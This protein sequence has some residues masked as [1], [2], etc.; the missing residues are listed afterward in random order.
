MT[1]SAIY[2]W[3]PFSGSLPV[4]IRQASAPIDAVVSESGDRLAVAGG[5]TTVSVWDTASGRLIGTFAPP[6]LSRHIPAVPL[7]VVLTADGDVVASGNSD[8][9]VSLWNVPTGKPVK[10]DTLSGGPIVELGATPDGSQLIAVNYPEV[11]AGITPPPTGEVLDASTGQVLATYHSPEGVAPDMNPGAALS[12]DGGFLLAGA[13]GLAPTSPG[14]TEAAYQISSGQA[15]TTLPAAGLSTVSAY[16][17][18]PTQPWSPD[19]TEVI[20]G[21]AI[22]SCDACGL[23]S[24]L[25]ATA[26]SRL[27][28]SRPLSQASD[29]P[30]ATNPY[31]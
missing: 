8:G 29:H 30:P 5:G 18:S 24:V 21:L 12:A 26:T 19:D 27:A 9:T 3:R 31:G 15:M 17:E 6:P 1:A 13:N 22:Y 14:G 11:V 25:E 28:W 4:V 16:S 10:V 7:R 20:A 23:T 2:L